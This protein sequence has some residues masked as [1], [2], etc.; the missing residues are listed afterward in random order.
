MP[1]CCYGNCQSIY[2]ICFKYICIYNYCVRNML[3]VIKCI[4]NC[5]IITFPHPTSIFY[6]VYMHVCMYAVF[7]GKGVISE[8]VIPGM[9]QHCGSPRMRTVAPPSPAAGLVY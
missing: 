2:L 3:F 6:K 5:F 9:R 8:Q 4:T 7:I 1:Y